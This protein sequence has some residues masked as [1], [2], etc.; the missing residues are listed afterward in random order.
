MK[1]I[2]VLFTTLL[3]ALSMNSCK[4]EEIAPPSCNCGVV[5]DKQEHIDQYQNQLQVIQIKNGCSS[6]IEWV[7]I[8]RVESHIDGVK[9]YNDINIGDNECVYLWNPDGSKSE[10]YW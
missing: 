9:S 2:K 8:L 7:N 5:M 4:K 10:Y 3:I 6:N 1:T